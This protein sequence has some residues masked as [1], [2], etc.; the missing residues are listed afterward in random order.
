MNKNYAFVFFCAF[1][2]L[3]FVSAETVFAS[4]E[5]S[6][7]LQLQAIDNDRTGDYVLVNDIDCSMTGGWNAGAGFNPIGDEGNPFTGTL[8]GQGYKID[9]LYIYRP[10][11]DYVGL[12]AY[13]AGANISNFGLTDEVVYGRVV[14]GGVV[15]DNNGSTLSH[16]YT[17]GVV[18]GTFYVGGILG[19]HAEDGALLE[20]SYSEATILATGNNA[21]GV[22]GV[23]YH[24]GTVTNCYS[25]GY[26]TSGGANKGGLVGE[27]EG[28]S[29]VTNSFYDSD[30]SGATDNTRGT[31]KTTVQM[32]TE[33]TFTGWDFTVVGDGTVGDWIM[34]G[35]PHLQM[36][37]RTTITDAVEL[38]LMQVDLGGDYIIT[39]DLD[40]SETSNW[41]NGAG[42]TPVGNIEDPFNGS[43]DG[44]GYE[45]SGLLLR[46]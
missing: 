19:G 30:T 44:N 37:H 36:D 35:Y 43:F 38:Q 21:G 14:V 9:D 1:F 5:I 15:G 26:V 16:V 40:V 34:A 29:T 8:N 2:A 39:D 24:T 45:I 4:T 20:D 31:P 6:T 18:N 3:N 13:A 12:I 10:T 46:M 33:G 23:V 27:L 17:T 32:Q 41:N 22:V 28:G 42:F 11:T 25:T 7:C